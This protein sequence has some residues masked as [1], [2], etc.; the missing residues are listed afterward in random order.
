MMSTLF[1][2]LLFSIVVVDGSA[3][4]P[5]SATIRQRTL[6]DERDTA[7]SAACPVS[8][9]YGSPCDIATHDGQVCDYDFKYMGCGATE[10]ELDC[11]PDIT[12]TC[13]DLWD[14]TWA[15][16][17]DRRLSMT[18]EMLVTC[19][20]TVSTKRGMT[21]TPPPPP[22]PTTSAA[23]YVT[24]GADETIENSNDSTLQTQG[25]DSAGTGGIDLLNTMN[26]AD[27]SAATAVDGTIASA[28][29]DTV[30][31]DNG[32]DSVEVTTT[33]A[34]VDDNG[35]STTITMKDVS[36]SDSAMSSLSSSSSSSLHQ[37][38]GVGGKVAMVATAT[39]TATAVGITLFL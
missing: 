33:P 23:E 16:P 38:F 13:N 11:L 39:A 3:H 5:P 4:A 29:K 21:C 24:D 27:D 19:P 22:P 18:E 15:C 17:Q 36:E 6:Q 9:E 1:V 14:E 8:L 10:E 31:S 34:V 7:A 32:M 25:S 26:G 30:D 35:S 12:C 2:L 37:G 20:D 28:S